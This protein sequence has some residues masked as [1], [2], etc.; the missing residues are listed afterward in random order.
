M[1]SH[2]QS[3]WLSPPFQ[4]S[5]SN[6]TCN[7]RLI[8]TLYRATFRNQSEYEGLNK[9][10]RALTSHFFAPQL[11]RP[12]IACLPL[13]RNRSL[14]QMVR[15]DEC[16][17]IADEAFIMNSLLLMLIQ[18]KYTLLFVVLKLNSAR[19]LVKCLHAFQRSD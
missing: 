1:Y 19:Q 17:T 2:V 10:C 3:V 12:S 13:L 7:C 5:V 4:S 8:L 11:S 9:I 6:V 14:D 15:P 16:L 18:W